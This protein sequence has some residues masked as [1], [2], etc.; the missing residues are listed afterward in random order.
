M[1]SQ[2]VR[3]DL[4]TKSR[5]TLLLQEPDLWVS[6]KPTCLPQQGVK[7]KVFLPQS[8]LCS[9]VRGYSSW[10]AALPHSQPPPSEFLILCTASVP[11]GR[12]WWQN[13]TITKP[14]GFALSLKVFLHPPH[15][16]MESFV[17]FFLS[18]PVGMCS[19]KHI[20]RMIPG[21]QLF[22]YSRNTNHSSLQGE[23]GCGISGMQWHYESPNDGWW[24]HE[25]SAGRWQG[26]KWLWHSLPRKQ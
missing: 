21:T 23:G 15:T 18:Y 26:I 9:F 14:W 5:A 7:V 12:W 1:E 16:S 4:A 22:A 8:C 24:W 25:I 13:F 20:L 2:R 17:K 10:L 11:S 3:H 6:H 19:R